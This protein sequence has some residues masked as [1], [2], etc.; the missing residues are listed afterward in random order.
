MEEVATSSGAF[1]VGQS[2]S[3]EGIPFGTTILGTG[4]GTLTLSA[5]ATK[6]T[7]ASAELAAT[8]ACTEADKA[9]TIAIS[10]AVE[11]GGDK[12]RFWAANPDGT[13][14][15]FATGSAF[16][17]QEQNLYE[18]NVDT[19]TPTLIAHKTFGLLGTSKD[20]SRIYFVSK[21]ALAQGAQEGQPNLYLSRE[22][23]PLSFIAMLSSADAKFIEA[24]ARLSP[25]NVEPYL[26]GART[27][28]DGES[29]AF[30][31]TASP[32]GY[33][34]TDLASGQADAEVYLYRAATG[35]LICAS[36]NPS[37]ARPVGRNLAG[38]GA[39]PFWMAAKLPNIENELYAQRLLSDDGQRLFFESF[40]SLVPADT[41]G[42]ED[43]YQWEAP[44]AG[45]CSAKSPSFS[46]QNEGCV[47][48]ISSG[49]SP[50]DSELLDASASGNDV[51]IRTGS[52]LMSQDPGLF[53]IYDARVGGGF[54]QPAP[55]PICEGEACQGPY[56]PPNDPTPASAS[57]H[58]AGNV[59][60]PP[61]EKC[62]KGKLRRHGRCVRKRHWQRRH[63]SQRLHRRSPG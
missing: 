16:S 28:P 22:G 10:E 62:G 8:S 17:E 29:A 45:T 54:P 27:S 51:F 44:G 31:S 60:E 61:A 11:E 30:I 58:G 63:R 3:G 9:C 21:E 26:H 18:L 2:V 20:L 38:A 56:S 42:A 52:S 57:F 49:E 4:P 15:L 37:G 40:D 47:D 39:D 46:P 41:N 55:A 1:A 48:L 19:G 23:K 24:G 32:T 33:D 50:Q 12:S 14:V 43:V 53:D 13:K 6:S 25:T 7:A 36:C 5:Q 59:V 34:N 35:K